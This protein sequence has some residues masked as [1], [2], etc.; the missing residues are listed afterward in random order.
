[1][2]RHQGLCVRHCVVAT[3]ASACLTRFW[4]QFVVKEKRIGS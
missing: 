4:S 3:A 2:S 1:M